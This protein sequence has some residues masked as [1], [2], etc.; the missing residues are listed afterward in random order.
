MSYP[1]QIGIKASKLD[2]NEKVNLRILYMHIEKYVICSICIY[3]YN[4]YKSMFTYAYIKVYVHVLVYM[5]ILICI[6][7]EAELTCGLAL[8]DTAAII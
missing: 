8:K 5:H 1:V 6:C 3:T 2:L 7:A 4:L